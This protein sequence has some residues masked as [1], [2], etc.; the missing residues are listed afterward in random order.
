MRNITMDD[1]VA[2][3]DGT[4]HGAIDYWQEQ[5]A[6]KDLEIMRLREAL[7]DIRDGM[8]TKAIN[9][10][11]IKSDTVYRFAEEITEA[12]STPTTY[13]DLM[14][15][16]EAQL[17][18]PEAWKYT[19]RDGEITSTVNEDFALIVEADGFEVTPLY[20]KKG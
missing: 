15:W 7:E 20:A 2:A 12:L 10:T 6:L 17:G 16:H 4:L 13:D 8:N 5:A 3:G 19:K 1:A 18:E 9:N 11:V 14:A